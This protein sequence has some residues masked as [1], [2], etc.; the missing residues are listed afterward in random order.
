MKKSVVTTYTIQQVAIASLLCLPGCSLIESFLGTKD[1]QSRAHKVAIEERAMEAMTQGVS[2]LAEEE[3]TGD[4]LI[5]MDGSPI[6]TT[7]SLQSEKEKLLDA[8]PQLKQMLDYMD[9]AQLDKN[10]A[11]GL[12]NQV[13]VDRYIGEQGVDQL[14]AYKKELR[15]GIK[16]VERMVNTKFFT[17]SFDVNITDANIRSF[18]DENKDA[19]PHLV[20][21]KGGVRATGISFANEQEARSFA[22]AAKAQGNDIQKTAAAQNKVDQIRD[23][24]T[25]NQQSFGI[26]PELKNKIMN[27]TTYPSVQVFTLKDG[28]AWVVSATSKEA[29]QYRPY[30]E[31]KADLKDYLEKEERAKRFDDEMSKLK[32]RYNIVMSEAYFGTPE[33]QAAQAA[34]EEEQVAALDDAELAEFINTVAYQE[35][36]GIRA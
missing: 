23:F 17:Q 34:A 11:E 10:L 21:A 30:E 8:N 25:V 33:E 5:T 15:D 27:I 19:M 22:D 20:L 26:D 6:V 7:N 35:S 13:I 4:A 14:P 9:P 24:T 2:V 1:E 12:M 3:L 16:A 31:V 36:S 18:Y 28:S 29:S 32:Q